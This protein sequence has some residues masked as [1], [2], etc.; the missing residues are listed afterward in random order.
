[1][2]KA[3]IVELLKRVKRYISKSGLDKANDLRKVTI[4]DFKALVFFSIGIT[5][6]I[7]N[8]DFSVMDVQTNEELADVYTHFQLYYSSEMS[9]IQEWEKMTMKEQGEPDIVQG[10]KRSTNANK[11]Q[12]FAHRIY[13]TPSSSIVNSQLNCSFASVVAWPQWPTA[14]G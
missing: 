9:R 5:T 8:T 12:V 13:T 3:K 2:R 1:M 4:N 7:K 6:K 10:F 14:S 11:Y